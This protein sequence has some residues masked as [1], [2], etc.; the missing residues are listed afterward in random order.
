MRDKK[1]NALYIKRS[2]FLSKMKW[3][4]KSNYFKARFKTTMCSLNTLKYL[5]NILGKQYKAIL[6][7]T[8]TAFITSW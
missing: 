8:V 3:D 5:S 6:K 7:G 4:K 1:M 2:S